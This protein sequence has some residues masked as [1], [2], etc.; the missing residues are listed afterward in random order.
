MS[1]KIMILFSILSFHS[2]DTLL[3]NLYHYW[4]ALSFIFSPV[5]LKTK[6]NKNQKKNQILDNN[7]NGKMPFFQI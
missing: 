4:F 1:E 6:Q 7:N 3:F 5:Y 2:E